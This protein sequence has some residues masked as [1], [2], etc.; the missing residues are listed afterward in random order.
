[1]LATGFRIP[2][3]VLDTGCRIN[4][5][6]QKTLSICFKELNYYIIL[7]KNSLTSTFLQLFCTVFIWESINP[8]SPI[9]RS[10][11]K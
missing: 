9:C 7:N 4:K 2:D 10:S 8:K 11:F 6:R 3:L 1:M 5:G